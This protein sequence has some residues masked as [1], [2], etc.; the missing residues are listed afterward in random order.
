[1]DAHISQWGRTFIVMVRCREWRLPYSTIF[2]RYSQFQITKYLT[3]S[4]LKFVLRCFTTSYIWQ[5]NTYAFVSQTSISL[6]P[7]IFY[8]F[9]S[10]HFISTG[11]V[12][13]SI[14]NNGM[15]KSPPVEHFKIMEVFVQGQRH[16]SIDL[17]TGPFSLLIR[18]AQGMPFNLSLCL[19]RNLLQLDFQYGF[20]CSPRRT[21]LCQGGLCGFTPKKILNRDIA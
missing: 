4:Y 9:F 17:F 18:N 14:R 12:C 11:G 1:M 5:L 21:I 8:I 2:W 10:F 15:N 13:L 20:L 16:Y 19:F 7:S 3:R 6:W